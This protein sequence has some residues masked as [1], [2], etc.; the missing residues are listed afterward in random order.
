MLGGKKKQQ[1]EVKTNADQ[2]DVSNSGAAEKGKKSFADEYIA[3]TGKVPPGKA[4]DSAGGH[5]DMQ[6]EINKLRQEAAEYKDQALR[7]GAALMNA[8]KRFEREKSEARAYAN[9]QMAKDIV[10]LR[11]NMRMALNSIDDEIKKDERILQVYRGIEMIE[12]MFEMALD[13]HGIKRVCP[14]I[15]DALDTSCH[16]AI[17][18]E[19]SEEGDAG[20]ILSV[21]K[22]G[23]TLNGRVLTP[24]MVVVVTKDKQT[25]G[26]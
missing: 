5:P 8:E 23:Y 24:A 11:E 3:K 19:F 18:S 7:A 12:K 25:E 14:S 26:S 13:N 6:E 16:H 2:G 21:V 1:Q 22:A 17:K 15:G 4:G 9:A 10:E 20:S